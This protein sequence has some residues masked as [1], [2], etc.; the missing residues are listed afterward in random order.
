MDSTKKGQ[1]LYT[2]LL[3]LNRSVFTEGFYEAAYHYLAAALH[4]AQALQN[5]QDAQAIERLALEQLKHI[6]EAAP[7]HNLSTKSVEARHGLNL[8]RQLA[9]LAATEARIIDAMEQHKL[10][11]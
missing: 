11:K 3:A 6:D 4:C 5:S 10:D 1:D 8:Y 7:E 2:E 9:N